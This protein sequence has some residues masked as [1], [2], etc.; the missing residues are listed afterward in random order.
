VREIKFRMWDSEKMVTPDYIDKEG[1]HLKN[2]N[3]I[4]E[5]SSMEWVMQFTGLHDKN[6]K[7]IYEGDVVEVVHDRGAPSRYSV[8]IVIGF[9][10]VE[11]EWDFISGGYECSTHIMKHDYSN[12][13][14]IGNIYGAPELLDSEGAER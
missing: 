14:V 8:L 5:Y 11:A 4:N 12:L 6:S 2:K 1:G 3:G 9:W 13:E 10:G 7:E